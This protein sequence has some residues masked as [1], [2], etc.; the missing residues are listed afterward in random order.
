MLGT[1]PTGMAHRRMSSMER[2]GML[3]ILSQDRPEL[4]GGMMKRFTTIDSSKETVVVVDPYSTGCV[5]VQEI[6][7]RGYKT[8]WARR[9]AICTRRRASSAGRGTALHPTGR[10]E[11][12]LGREGIFGERGLSSGSEADRQRGVRWRQ[13]M[14][15]V[16]KFIVACLWYIRLTAHS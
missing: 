7:S 4:R 13:A 8:T 3:R 14:R 10:R 5:I 11:G 9:R 2:P 1:L 12:I 6:Q 15:C 16:L